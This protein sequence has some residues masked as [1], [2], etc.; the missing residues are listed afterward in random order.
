MASWNDL[1]TDPY[2]IKKQ[3]D[4]KNIKHVNMVSSDMNKCKICCD[5]KYVYAN[6]TF[7]PG[8]IVEICPTRK[9]DNSSLYSDDMRKIVFE[10]VPNSVYVIPFGYCQYY[11]IVSEDNPY[12][13]CEYL[14]DASKNVI[15]IKAICK[16]DKYEQLILQI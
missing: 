1:F 11:S 13:N 16:I 5:G 2:S 6:T 15:I 7:Y 12:A 3:R 14:W 4:K 8:D 10:V 9:I